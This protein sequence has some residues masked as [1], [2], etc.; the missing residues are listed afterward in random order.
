MPSPV[1][2]NFD[3][4]WLEHDASLAGRAHQEL[5]VVG[6]KDVPS[7]CPVAGK[8]KLPRLRGFS[9]PERLVWGSI[10]QERNLHSM[11]P[12]PRDLAANTSISCPDRLPGE[13]KKR[14]ST[15]GLAW[16]PLGT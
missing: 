13:R 3:K 12:T 10:T 2:R 6:T 5:D 16:G 7:P 4:I 11:L 15:E 1:L 9:E 14:R 8:Q